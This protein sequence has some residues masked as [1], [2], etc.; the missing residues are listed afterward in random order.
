MS[1]SLSQKNT[2]IPP[3]FAL[4]KASLQSL[5]NV[6]S[7]SIMLIDT[8]GIIL[9]A[10]ETASARLGKSLTHLIGTDI[11]NALPPHIYQSRKLYIEKVISSHM[12]HSFQDQRNGRN[13][14]N[15]LYPVLDEQDQVV[16]IAIFSQD[17]TARL[18]AEIE[19]VRLTRELEQLVE[20]QTRSLRESEARYRAVAELTS[21]YIFQASL[22]PGS[23]Y[24]ILWA[25]D[26]IKYITGYTVDEL[27]STGWISIVH[28]DDTLVV[29]T[30][31]ARLDAGLPFTGNMRI[32]TRN[33]AERWMQFYSQPV[34]NAEKSAIT[35]Y[36]GAVYDITSRVHANMKLSRRLEIE[37]AMTEIANVFFKRHDIDVS[38]L[39]ALELT[40]RVSKARRIRLFL[41][42]QQGSQIESLYTAK[43]SKDAP[44]ADGVMP[45]SI[46]LPEIWRNE[47]ITGNHIFIT[48]VAEYKEKNLQAKKILDRLNSNSLL[49]FPVRSEAGFLGG[50]C[51]EL[52]SAQEN[53]EEE[54]ISLLEVEAQ[55]I[56]SALTR[57]H[58]LGTLEERIQA[59]T[60]HLT[61]LYDLTL[62]N[63][64]QD[65]IQ[66]MLE[67]TIDRVLE[68]L[69]CR[70]GCIHLLDKD[71]NTL[72]LM[73][74]RWISPRVAS[75]ID[76]IPH[77]DPLWGNIID[78]N[79][80]L[81]V[82]NI[83]MDGRT[84]RLNELYGVMSF[85]GAPIHSKN[86]AMGV[87]SIFITDFS[88][89]N[90][91]DIALLSAIA[92]QIGM[93]IDNIRLRKQASQAAV[94]EERQRLGRELHDSVTQSLYSLSLF[95]QVGFNYANIGEFELTAHFLKRIS[96]TTQNALKEMRLL[97]YELRPEVLEHEG[98][99]GAL[100]QRLEIVERRVGI[101]TQL[102][103][104]EH[105]NL[106]PDLETGLFYIAQEALNNALKHSGA[107]KTTVEITTNSHIVKLTINDNGCGFDMLS[108]D[109]RS[110][111][112]M[113]SMHERAEKL[114]C[115]LHI[116]S[117]AGQGT[118]VQV[119]WFNTV[120]D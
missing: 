17:I 99:V 14:A 22:Q 119:V 61:A 69:N 42:D 51:L 7:E 15:S 62:I 46:V 103:A 100:R 92:D 59:R 8:Q 72:K 41:V 66:I 93:T 97:I 74:H 79:K 110:G 84:Q 27:N 57:L 26:S 19:Q 83:K 20:Q 52:S 73:A 36:F 4:G 30:E 64:Q 21:D 81:A 49:I 39:N 116:I 101:E 10:N 53:W 115:Y 54:I 76:T 114:G 70:V 13:Y 113:A 60:R 45:I 38:I 16:Q 104:P 78:E 75:Q 1:C 28:P 12:P 102:L 47:L 48:D 90:Q 71:T 34:W 33:G 95:S 3:H 43:G 50:L 89:F 112:G 31:R 111:I 86:Q 2:Q 29:E 105:L 58:I 25:T 108:D 82:I 117:T 96:D 120:K 68:A 91:E 65:D 107:T 67:Q 56:G 106:P 63:S 87:I 9:A 5:F 18:Q 88:S 94:L 11:S 118:S 23:E 40:R 32:I 77:D 44:E 35:S 80:P 98:L 37:R 109:W 6:I 85:I 55:I 24:Q